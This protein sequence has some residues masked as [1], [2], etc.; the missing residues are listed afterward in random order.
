MYTFRTSYFQKQMHTFST[1]VKFPVIIHL[2][3]MIMQYFFLQSSRWRMCSLNRIPQE[4]LEEKGNT[5]RLLCLQTINFAFH[6]WLRN[7]L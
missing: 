7:Y 2:K 1:T 4:N 6:N 3:I 5:Y